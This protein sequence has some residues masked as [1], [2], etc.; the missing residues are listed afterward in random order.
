MSGKK[1]KFCTAVLQAAVIITEMDPV[2]RDRHHILI[3]QENGEAVTRIVP[4]E[5]LSA[6]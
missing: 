3:H 6:S 2:E 5:L 1:I 4:L